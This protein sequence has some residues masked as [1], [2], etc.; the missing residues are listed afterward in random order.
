[1]PKAPERHPHSSVEQIIVPHEDM[2]ADTPDQAAGPAYT[3]DRA[4]AIAALREPGVRCCRCDLC[5]TRTQVVFG[6]GS[7]TA[8]LLIIGEAPGADEDRSGHPFWGRAGQVLNSLLDAAGITREQVWITNTVKCRPSKVNGKRVS[9]RAPRVPEIKAC[10]IWRAGELDILKPRV[11]VCLGAVAAKA[12]MGRD[13]KMTTERGQWFQFP[14][15]IEGMEHS[16]VTV[17]YHPS[18]IMRQEG[19]AYDRIRAQA[20]ADFAAIASK[21]SSL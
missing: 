1:M 14:M 9:N 15:P 4:T 2:L 11:V 16:E 7:P 20:D 17:T 21:L 12:I 13:V 19:E 18:Y 6:E 3:A 5:A 10:E 8:S